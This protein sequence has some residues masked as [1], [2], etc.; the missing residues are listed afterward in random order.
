MD[1]IFGI[2]LGTTLSEISYLKNGKPVVVTLENGRKYLPSVVGIDPSGKIITG[3]S[4]RNQYAAF[5]ENTVVS[6]KRKMGS[7][8]TFTMGAKSYT[9]AEISA[10]ILK[11]LKS[12][13]EKEAGVPVEKAVITVPAYFTDVQRKDTIKAGEIAGLE[14]VRIINEPTAAAL[15]YGCREDGLEKILVYDLGGGTFDVSL[16]IVEEGVIEVLASDGNSQLGGDDFDHRLEEYFIS[17]LP[18][19]AVS[20]KDLRLKARLENIAETVKI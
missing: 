17:N 2:D 20:P 4:A 1:K 13:A 9:P 8:Q 3:F 18:K 10:E 11:T 16:I 12:F 14:V 7:G 15:A 6:V 5:P 19:N